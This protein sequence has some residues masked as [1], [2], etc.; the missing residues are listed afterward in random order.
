MCKT[1][2]KC[3]LCGAFD[4]EYCSECDIWY[5]ETCA[6]SGCWHTATRTVNG[7]MQCNCSHKVEV[8]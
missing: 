3:N 4:I 8:L 2:T 5:E 7:V 6:Y 1:N